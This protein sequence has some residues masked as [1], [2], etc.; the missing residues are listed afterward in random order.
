MQMWV[1]K[2]KNRK[3]FRGFRGFDVLQGALNTMKCVTLTPTLSLTLTVTLI[4]TDHS[5]RA[6][7]RGNISYD[8]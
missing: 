7:G 8:W 5:D 1:G 3:T 4:K 6:G 2:A